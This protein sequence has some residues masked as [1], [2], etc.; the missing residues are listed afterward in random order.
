[1]PIQAEVLT[2]RVF[3]PVVTDDRPLLSRHHNV[4]HVLK[5]RVGRDHV[6]VRFVVRINLLTI[7][8][9]TKK[10]TKKVK[11]NGILIPRQKTTDTGQK[12]YKKLRS[13]KHQHC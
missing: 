9:Q 1:M 2:H 4:D 5:G 8:D 3:L 13:L 7:L 6:V 10:Y 11:A 12:D